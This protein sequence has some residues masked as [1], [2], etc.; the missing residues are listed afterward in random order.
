LHT[1]DSKLFAIDEEGDTRPVTFF[2]DWEDDEAI[3]YRLNAPYKWI[4][5]DVLKK[6]FWLDS[7]GE[8]PEEKENRIQIFE[9]WYNA[10]PKL[11]PILGHRYVVNAPLF[12]S[13]PIVSS[14]GTDT[15]VYAWDMLHYLKMDIAFTH[16][17]FL[18]KE[19]VYDEY[20]KQYINVLTDEMENFYNYNGAQFQ[21]KMISYWGELIAKNCP[22][23]FE[24][25]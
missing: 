8:K 4:L 25:L 9:K 24:Y 6:T 18:K 10:A 11:I 16:P 22:N 7:W 2:H 1:I 12:D 13:F 23:S 15:I 17:S 3:F 19:K 21:Y 20:L 14:L 5:E